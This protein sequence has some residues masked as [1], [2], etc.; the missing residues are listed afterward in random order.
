MV[1]KIFFSALFASVSTCT[2]AASPTS[3][4]DYQAIKSALMAGKPITLVTT[5]DHCQGQRDGK[6]R[7]IKMV[8]GLQIDSFIIPDDKYIIFSDYHQRLS[9]KEGLPEVEFTR[10][11]VMPD[12]H[13]LIETKR[14]SAPSS[15]TGEKHNANFSPVSWN[16]AI[17]SSAQFYTPQ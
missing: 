7:N 6:P 10:Y 14:F 5:F 13:L 17:G 15:A 16:C 8:G 11:K 9:D 3:L 1:K 4:N 2:F 12:N